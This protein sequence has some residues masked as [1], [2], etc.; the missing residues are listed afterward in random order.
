VVTLSP[1]TVTAVSGSGEVAGPDSGDPSAMENLLL[2][3]GQSM[4]LDT[5]VTW[6]P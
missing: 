6:H 4:V 3:H 2:W 5:L 1:S